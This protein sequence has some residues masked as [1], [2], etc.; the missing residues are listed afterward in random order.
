MEILMTAVRGNKTK[1]GDSN[2]ARH[3]QVSHSE[4]RYDNIAQTLHLKII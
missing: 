1:Q 4:G 2:S 3:P